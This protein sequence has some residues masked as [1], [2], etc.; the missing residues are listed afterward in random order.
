[1]I[2]ADAS[3]P[4]TEKKEEGMSQ[5]RSP[6]RR[7]MLLGLG[8]AA[9]LPWNRR[10]AAQAYPARNFRVIVPTGQGGGADTLARAFVPSWST[11]LQG[12]RFEFEFN[13]AASGQV[14]YELFINRRERDGYNLLFGNMGP[15]MVMYVTQAPNYRFP[16]DY[17]YFCGV[18]IDDTGIFARRDSPF[19]TVQDVIEQARRRT[20]NV[21]VT[22]IPHPGSIGMLTLADALGARFNLIPY[23]GGNP[24]VTAVLNGEADIGAGGI[25]G[26]PNEGNGALKVLCVFNRRFNQLASINENAPLVNAALG[27]NLPDLYTSRSWA[28][29]AEW[30]RANPE[31]F[32]FLKSTA[33]QVFDIPKFK[34]DIQRTT[35]PWDA[36]RY[37]DEASCTEYALALVELAQRYRSVLTARPRR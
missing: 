3:A 9:S 23:G 25:S 11:L 8:A 24:A 7:S 17:V 13:P 2:V 27:T 4:A 34:E 26:V 10:A 35:Q 1:V 14:A 16:Q 22:R 12:R 32:E 19:K 18:D 33:R 5:S 30:A 21:S 31:S 20:L 15:E 29:H 6:T 37:I 36:V 28:V